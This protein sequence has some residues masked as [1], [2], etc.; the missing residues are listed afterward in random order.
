MTSAGGDADG[1]SAPE[2][3]SLTGSGH[4]AWVE[5]DASG[6]FHYTAPFRWI[7]QVEH[8]FYRDVV[9][10]LDLGSLPRRAVHATYDRALRM[11]DPWTVEMTVERIGSTSATYA[12]RVL[13]G[14]EL[15]VNGG[16]T[17][18]H[19]DEDGRP[20]PLPDQLVAGLMAHQ[21]G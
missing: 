1:G 19:V 13:S 18:V 2:S 3:M 7:E 12:W 6:R 21:R 4:L 11:G 14:D 8:A 20:A 16:H 10:S 9:P 5:T 15:C 17:V